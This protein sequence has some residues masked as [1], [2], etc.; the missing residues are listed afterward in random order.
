MTLDPLDVALDEARQ[1]EERGV[2][3]LFRALNPGLVRYLRHHARGMEEDLA[4]EVWASASI[5]LPRFEG[6]AR[7]FRALLFTLARRRMVDHYR[8][9][10]RAPSIVALSEVEEPS[11]GIDVGTAVVSDLSVQEAIEVL[12]KGLPKTQA[13]VILLRVVGD[14]S[15]EEV[16]EVLGRSRGSV[17]VLQHRALQRLAKKF[18][19]VVTP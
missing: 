7:G 8:R 4:S 5:A 6:D 19:K 1:G 2:V 13:E 14:L 16:A 9:T 10:G 17:R 11:D 3:A 15:V 12:V 18:K